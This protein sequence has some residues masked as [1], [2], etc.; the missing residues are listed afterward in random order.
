MHWS[1]HPSYLEARR[2]A[3]GR[4][5]AR[6]VELQ[7]V[8]AVVFLCGAMG[9]AR[10]RSLREY[11]ERHHPDLLVFY[12]E[13][14]WEQIGGDPLRNALELETRL[15]DLADVLVLVIESAGTIAE[16]GAFA[17]NSELRR[18]LLPVLGKA[19]QRDASF[20]VSGPVRWVDRDSRFAPSLWTNLDS[21][22]LCGAE[23]NERLSRIPDRGRLVQEMKSRSLAERPK[24]LLLLL[25]DVVTVLG[26]ATGE[27]CEA[28]V[29]DILLDTPTWPIRDLLALAVALKLVCRKEC[30]GEVLYWRPL[31]AGELVPFQRA[32]LLNLA[33]ERARMLSVLMKFQ[34][35]RDALS[36][37]ST[38]A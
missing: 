36:Q 30:D 2:R 3:A 1:N 25:C 4:F 32:G 27:A 21:I 5:R 37:C 12:A 19:H 22:L 29:R 18:K 14:V 16:L 11:I 35:A 10:R 26:P 38:H 28:F 9:S 8:R 17:V 15:A 24:H 34:G 31:E 13:D 7:H 23:L 6:V 33:Q 20:I